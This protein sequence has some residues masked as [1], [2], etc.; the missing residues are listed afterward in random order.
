MRCRRAPR[1]Q[2]AQGR[3]TS[4]SVGCGDTANEIFPAF[5]RQPSCEFRYARA[6]LLLG[7]VWLLLGLPAP[8]LI[9]QVIDL[10]FQPR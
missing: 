1:R 9:Q 6:E 4:D 7:E 3:L 2:G 10:L 8:L 5:L